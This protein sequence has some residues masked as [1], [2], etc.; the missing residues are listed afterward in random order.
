M[1][2]LA[3]PYSNRFIAKSAGVI[4]F[5]SFCSRIL[6]LVRDL[7]IARVFGVL[8]YSQAFVVAFK[9][10]NLFRD[11]VGEGSSNAAFIPVFSEYA[12]N[13][14]TEFWQ[15]SNVVLNLLL[16][17]LSAVTIAGI[18][19]APLLIRVIAPGFSEN[20]DKFFLTVKLTRLIFP[21][22]V[23][24]GL[25]A[26]SMALLNTLKHFTVPAFAPALLNISI[27]ICALL[28][29]E[30]ILGLSSG[31][32]FGGLL[33]LA[34]QLPVLYKKGFCVTLFKQFNHPGARKIGR[35][36]VPRIFSSCVYQL[37]NFVDTIFGSFARVV[38]EG[39]VSI[40]YFAYRLVQFPLGIFSNALS[41]AML[42][43]LSSRV[44][45]NDRDGLN[46]S[47]LF[48]LR[49]VFFVMLPASVGLMVLSEPIISALFGG[50]KFDRAAVLVTANVLSFYSIGLFSYGATKIINNGFF[51]LHDT[52]TP[53][54]VS[55]FA[56]LLNIAFNLFFIFVLSLKISGIA[57]ATSVS[58]IITFLITFILLC[59]KLENFS[60]NLLIFSFARILIASVCMGICCF[61]VLQLLNG[62]PLFNKYVKL[63]IGV[64]TGAI[65]YP[66]FCFVF[67]VTEIKEFFKWVNPFLRSASRFTTRF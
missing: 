61:L 21:Y 34:V 27:I 65:S 9:I 63:T 13:R 49:A 2:I 7:V 23:M 3:S 60:F 11:I 5:A 45:E 32:L 39:G 10:P 55:F 64:F 15:L 58:G 42:P 14:K 29:G 26:Y 36:L 46:L 17:L 57:L 51:A 35:L 8:S 24:I 66:L 44:L 48:G 1:S 6:G 52:R 20:S 37:N 41:T 67:K 50:G 33:Q 4:G 16:V 19:F 31:I 22:L 59:K 30:S 18:L 28:F 43:A 40:L 54:W 53:A 12:K 56:L 25:S 62:A 38:G 47:L